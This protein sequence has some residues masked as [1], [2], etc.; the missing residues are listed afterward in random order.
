MK[1]EPTIKCR[2]TYCSLVATGHTVGVFD[3]L[4]DRFA[5]LDGKGRVVLYI[6]RLDYDALV[7]R[8]VLKPARSSDFFGSQD[9]RDQFELFPGAA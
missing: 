3:L 8:G 7:A 5:F 9:E 1:N 2:F 6:G 4:K